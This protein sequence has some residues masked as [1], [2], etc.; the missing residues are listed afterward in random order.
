MLLVIST[1]FRS[2]IIKR[3][4]QY[5]YYKRPNNLL[6]TDKKCQNDVGKRS[7]VVLQINVPI[8]V[9]I[10]NDRVK[11]FWSLSDKYFCLLMLYNFILICDKV[12]TMCVNTV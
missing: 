8:Y 2:L 10:D 4:L 6:K 5:Y 11:T 1:T 9:W 7:I 12:T 3:F